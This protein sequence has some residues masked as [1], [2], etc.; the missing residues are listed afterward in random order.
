[1]Q[2]TGSAASRFEPIQTIPSV[3]LTPVFATLSRAEDILLVANYNGADDPEGAGV[4]AFHI[5]PDCK[6]ALSSSI[7][8]T[9]SSVDAV[10]Q[11]QAHTH[12][13][14]ASRRN[15]FVY[16]FDLGMDKIFTYQLRNGQL[17]RRAQVQ[18]LAASGPRHGV[19]HP[20]L[21]ILYVICELGNIVLVYQEHEDGRLILR[22]RLT[23]ELED[24]SSKSAEIIITKSGKHLYTSTR[25]EKESSNI[26]TVFDV[27]ENG[28]LKEIQHIEAPFY[29]RGMTLLHQDSLLLV[30]GQ[31]QG[32]MAVYTVASEGMLT[33]KY[34][35]RQG[36]PPNPA[37]FA[38]LQDPLAEF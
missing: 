29:P 10:R 30:A 38:V 9:G 7:G 5:K 25:G 28:H 33:Q 26:V 8:H 14:V 15:D 6:L 12:G 31:S 22:Q 20:S 35:I 13:L 32:D 18:A 23:I 16:A 11:V 1:L 3:G 4:A 37:A 27:L 21:P 17:Q 34:K 2:G 24:E 36:L 19:E